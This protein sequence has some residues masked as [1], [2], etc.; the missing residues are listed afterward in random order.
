[1]SSKLESGSAKSRDIKST[2]ASIFDSITVVG[3]KGRGGATP[4]EPGTPVEMFASGG[5]P[6]IFSPKRTVTVFLWRFDEK[7]EIIFF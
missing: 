1:M 4:I 6:F 7:I 5:A 3:L 2:R